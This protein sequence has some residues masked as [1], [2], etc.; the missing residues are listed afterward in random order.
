MSQRF[1]SNKQ[2]FDL[3][4]A[5]ISISNFSTQKSFSN[6]SID[7]PIPSLMSLNT[8]PTTSLTQDQ[9]TNKQ[10]SRPNPTSLKDMP[11]PPPFPYFNESNL[12]IPFSTQTPE[13][14]EQNMIAKL[15]ET[16]SY[17]YPDQLFKPNNPE[18]IHR[19]DKNNHFTQN[20]KTNNYVNKYYK[21]Q[22]YD[23][24]HETGNLKQQRDL[25]YT[26][27]KNVDEFKSAVESCHHTLIGRSDGLLFRYSKIPHSATIE[28]F[29]DGINVV[30]PKFFHSVEINGISKN[31][32]SSTADELNNEHLFI[33]PPFTDFYIR[34]TFSHLENLKLNT[35]ATFVLPVWDICFYHPPAHLSKFIT[36]SPI[37]KFNSRFHGSKNNIQHLYFTVYYHF[38]TD[39]DK[40]TYSPEQ[41]KIRSLQYKAKH[42]HQS[43][44]LS[45]ASTHLNAS[46]SNQLSNEPDTL[47]D[48]A[49]DLANSNTSST[50]VTSTL[51]SSNSEINPD[52]VLKQDPD[53]S[54]KSSPNPE[55]SSDLQPDCIL[56]NKLVNFLKPEYLSE[57]K[58]II[59]NLKYPP[60]GMVFNSDPHVSL[61][62]CASTIFSHETKLLVLN[63]PR[64]AAIFNPEPN[65]FITSSCESATVELTYSVMYKDKKLKKTVPIKLETKAFYENMPVYSSI[66][67][68]SD[69]II[70][71]TAEDNRAFLSEIQDIYP[72]K[73]GYVYRFDKHELIPVPV[74][75]SFMI[76]APSS[77]DMSTYFDLVKTDPENRPAFSPLTFSNYL[78]QILDSS[79][80][81]SITRALDQEIVCSSAIFN[82]FVNKCVKVNDIHTPP[83]FRF[84]D[85]RDKPF[86]NS[87]WFSD[88]VSAF[89][90][91]TVPHLPT[92]LIHPDGLPHEYKEFECNNHPSEKDIS[93]S[94]LEFLPAIFSVADTQIS[95]KKSSPTQELKVKDA[96]SKLI[97]YGTYV[98][99]IEISPLYTAT[100]YASNLKSSQASLSTSL[101]SSV[102]DNVYLGSIIIHST[103]Q[104]QLNNVINNDIALHLSVY[105]KDDNYIIERPVVK[106]SSVIRS[107]VLLKLRKCLSIRDIFDTDDFVDNIR[108]YLDNYAKELFSSKQYLPFN[109]KVDGFRPNGS[110]KYGSNI[111]DIISPS[112]HKLSHSS[113]VDF[114]DKSKLH[115]NNLLMSQFFHKLPDGSTTNVPYF[116]RGKYDYHF[117]TA[118][119]TSSIDSAQTFGLIPTNFIPNHI[120]KTMSNIYDPSVHSSVSSQRIGFNAFKPSSTSNTLHHVCEFC[121]SVYPSMLGSIL[122]K[123]G[124]L[125]STHYTDPTNHDVHYS[126]NILKSLPPGVHCHKLLARDLSIVFASKPMKDFIPFKLFPKVEDQLCERNY[127]AFS[128]TAFT[129]ISGPDGTTQHKVYYTR[130]NDGN[131]IITRNRPF[132]KLMEPTPQKRSSRQFKAPPSTSN[133]HRSRSNSNSSRLR[134]G[135][136]HL[137]TKNNSSNN[138]RATSVIRVPLTM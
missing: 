58:D 71:N 67:S 102:T 49:T 136:S 14:V 91:C 128:L 123:A 35:T 100:L 74:Q 28:C 40:L 17:V 75:P 126:I 134:S 42:Q 72:T 119:S 20:N 16:N 43:S 98:S 90:N 131:A 121:N 127:C 46:T 78:R 38:S 27:F 77:Y 25:L 5:A 81:L 105:V 15:K 83:E 44:N 2:G 87:V 24:A 125:A 18:N 6:N 62:P 59:A 65:E 137:F 104:D 26:N 61:A 4:K 56:F 32:F 73:E 108:K 85:I 129:T 112:I 120:L 113:L 96:T 60:A 68:T 37:K 70:V 86:D 31:F 7:Q 34:D 22:T 99:S 50:Q 57:A 63:V 130:K 107:I 45:S 106:D 117:A 13:S 66:P 64:D 54:S 89:C 97:V 53:Q 135:S 55:L 76:D 69:R 138:T 1:S 12:E 93:P 88:K 10:A 29:T 103:V 52:D 82:L 36:V 80:P 8:S 101:R 95:L 109:T 41:I 21:V 30:C 132:S 122:C 133:N 111:L 39:I 110:D 114:L 33:H 3:N 23:L 48:T 92:N 115:S 11:T 118:P 84:R 51:D 124:H 19:L 94:F 47:K 9:K 79:L 116:M